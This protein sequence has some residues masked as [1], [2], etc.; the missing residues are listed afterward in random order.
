VDQGYCG[1]CYAFAAINAL[2][3]A[4]AIKRGILYNLSEQQIIDCDTGNYGCNGGWP[5]TALTYAATYALM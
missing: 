2:E 5:D 4:Y 1:S 3:S